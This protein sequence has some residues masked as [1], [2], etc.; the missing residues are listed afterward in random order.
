MPAAPKVTP[1][2]EYK[3]GLTQRILAPP[4][5]G[6]PKPIALITPRSLTPHG[7]GK[8]RPRVSASATRMS[9]SPADFF[10]SSTLHGTPGSKATSGGDAGLFVPR[11]DPRR[12]LIRDE[13][14]LPSSAKKST[15]LSGR[16]PNAAAAPGAQFGRGI[17][18]GTPGSAGANGGLYADG[19]GLHSNGLASLPSPLTLK[20][21]SPQ[22]TPKDNIA[23]LPILTREG[24]SLEPSMK[25]LAAMAMDDP[26]SLKQV[27]NFTVRK[28]GVGSVT[29]LETVD[30][31]NLD[32][33]A[34]VAL[35]Q[36][37]IDVYPDETTKPPVG[38]GLNRPAVI[39]MLNIFK[40][41][42][43][44]GLPTKDPELVEKYSKKLKAVCA[45]QS[46]RFISYDGEKGVW[47]FET[48]H[49]SRYGLVGTSDDEDDVDGDGDGAPGKAAAGATVA[50]TDTFTAINDHDS[51]NSDF[52]DL[53]DDSDGFQLG[54]KRRYERQAT[55][56]AEATVTVDDEI[57]AQRPPVDV[58]GSLRCVLRNPRSGMNV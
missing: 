3:V 24:Y 42:K 47:K 7:G 48:E 43:A 51:A 32:L 25:Q 9:K 26:Q 21:L 35:A 18:N 28:Q 53:S 52:S 33:D 57:S 31:R 1:L 39:T 17:G 55:G 36:G 29:W 6:P 22:N 19:V 56:V 8:I 40:L 41:D 4:S 54:I 10:A 30:V 2:P 11:E 38:N 46:A 34:I 50:A 20:S 16:T 49:F 13:L 5:A 23:V 12:L 27:A 37:S 15:S 14:P 58:L 44:T 45:S